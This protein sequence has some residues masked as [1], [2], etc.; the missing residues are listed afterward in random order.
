MS[1]EAAQR[2]VV[3]KAKPV[4][5]ILTS[6]PAEKPKVKQSKKEKVQEKPVSVPKKTPR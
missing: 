5:V 6:G 2:T 4:A 3:E 1:Q